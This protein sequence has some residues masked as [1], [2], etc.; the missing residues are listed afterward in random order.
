[1]AVKVVGEHGAR[2]TLHTS[3][4]LSGV[5]LEMQA[6]ERLAPVDAEAL[7]VAHVD[8]ASHDRQVV[9]IAVRDIDGSFLGREAL[10]VANGEAKA[11]VTLVVGLP[12]LH[13][14]CNVLDVDARA[15][16]LPEAGVGWLASSARIALV[17]GLLEELAPQTCAKLAD[18]VSLLALL[19]PQ[20]ALSPA[21]T[22]LAGCVLLGSV[23]RRLLDDSL[24][25]L[26]SDR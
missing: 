5:D 24:G 6:I 23:C 22:L 7:L 8:L 2:D 14:V 13:E 3:R 4:Q 19:G 17:T 26:R 10:D 16:N 12:V 18:L 21:N 9:A 25:R 15:G 1:M 20:R 11:D